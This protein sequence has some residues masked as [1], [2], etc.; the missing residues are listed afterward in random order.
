LVKHVHVL[1]FKE[2]TTVIALERGTLLV[3]PIEKCVCVCLNKR[4]GGG[5]GNLLIEDVNFSNG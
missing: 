5:V 3:A 4:R 1:P 2:L